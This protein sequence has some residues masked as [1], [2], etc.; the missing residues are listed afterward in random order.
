MRGV[1]DGAR[2]FSA[3]REGKRPH[4]HGVDHAEDR[5]RAADAERE[6]EQD[7]RRERWIPPNETEGEPEIVHDCRAT[8]RRGGSEG[9]IGLAAGRRPELAE[10][11][12]L[13]QLGERQAL[14]LG[15]CHAFGEELLVTVLQMLRQ[16]VGDL[17]L[18]LRGE[19]QRLEVRAQRC[20]PVRHTPPPR[21]G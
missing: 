3:F 1:P 4:H 6:R 20:S 21:C 16:L 19:P 11:V 15:R 12:V 13:G 14:R 7:E 10:Q 5:G 18:A 2:R 17:G 8:L 9:E